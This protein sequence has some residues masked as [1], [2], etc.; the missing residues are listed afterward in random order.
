MVRPAQAKLRWLEAA[1]PELQVAGIAPGQVALARVAALPGETLRGKVAAVLPEINAET[2]TLRV[3]IELPNPQQRL[4]AGM[5]AQVTLQGP[6]AGDAVVLPSDKAPRVK[7]TL[8]PA[9]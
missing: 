4:R 5:F 2:R 3:R 6:A 7:V 8:S 1:L 9:L